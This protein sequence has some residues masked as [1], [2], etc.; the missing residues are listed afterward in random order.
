MWTYHKLCSSN[1]R[2]DN[3]VVVITGAN[4]GIGKET[5]RDFYRR[6]ARVILACRNMEKARNA[7]KDIKNNPFL[8]TDNEQ[9]KSQLGDL[10]IYSLD[11]CSLKSVRECAKKL[12]TSESAIHILVNNAG[13][14][15]SPHKKTEDGF[16]LQL[17]SNHLGH[18]LLTLLLL[19][20]MQSSAPGCRIVNVSSLAH[21]F[22]KIHFNDMNLDRSYGALKAY[23]QSKLANILFTKELAHQLKEAGINGINVYSLHPGVVRTELGRYYNRTIIP[24]ATFFYYHIMRPFIKSSVQGA[25]TTIHCAVDKKVANETGLYYSECRVTRPQWRARDDQMAKDLW[26]HTCRLLHLE[27]D[28]NFSTFLQTV[29]HQ[30]A[31]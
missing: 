21:V 23:A 26:D 1:A 31:N 11:L 30:L 5:A 22:G 4:T 3:K 2:L 8:S 7:V 24:G 15:M 20:K 16:E 9:Y 6:G 13:I 14:M 10:A 19:P 12:L 29:S 28:T 27:P 17:Q 18:F 25:Q